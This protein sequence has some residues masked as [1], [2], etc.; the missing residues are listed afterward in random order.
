MG[1]RVLVGGKPHHVVVAHFGEKAA[2]GRCSCTH[3]HI[4]S[5]GRL[6]IIS[7]IDAGGMYLCVRKSRAVI[8]LQSGWHLL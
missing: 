2:I 6:Y 1:R 7:K 4:G 8:V 3:R 5:R